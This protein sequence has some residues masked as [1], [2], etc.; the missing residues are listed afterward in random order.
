M[1]SALGSLKGILWI[2]ASLRIRSLVRAWVIRS[3]TLLSSNSMKLVR[4]G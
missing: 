4:C 1:L 2:S 3:T